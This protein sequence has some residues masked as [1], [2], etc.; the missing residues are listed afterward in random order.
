MKAIRQSIGSFLMLAT[1]TLAGSSDWPKAKVTIRV[2]GEDGIA[3][4]NATVHIGFSQGGNAWIGEHKG[5]VFHGQS[6]SNG[7]YSAEARS[8][9]SVGGGVEKRGY[10]RSFWEYT[11]G[12]DY[13]VIKRWEPWN[14]TITVVLCRVVDPIPMYARRV[15][16]RSE[17]PIVGEP[18]GYDLMI[19]DWVAPHGRGQ[20]ADFL[21]T[22]NRRV[23]N[24]KDFETH[25][26][27]TFSNPLD[28]IQTIRELGPRGS[29]FRLPRTAPGSSYQTAWTNSIGYIP[30]RG[31]FQTQPKDCL[32]YLFRVR[33]VADNKGTPGGGLY[34][35]VKG[36]IEFDARDSDTAHIA[37]TYY[38]NPTPNDRNLEFDPSRNLFKDL[39]P[40]EQVRE[41]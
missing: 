7:C 31:Y 19:G 36:P 9:M 28:G 1:V 11:F 37:F 10:Y 12:G 13:Q 15:P 40:L 39:S 32:G 20:I 41:P 3:V 2:V 38:L 26:S 6:D 24:W 33:S 4:S 34:G 21:F 5:E 23:A 14:P 18:V 25:L 16:I 35:K 8:E 17:M 29:T 22:V 27:L 30:G